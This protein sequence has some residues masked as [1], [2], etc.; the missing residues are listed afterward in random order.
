MNTSMPTPETRTTV[1]FHHND[2]T[3]NCHENIAYLPRA[4]VLIFNGANASIAVDRENV[5]RVSISG[6]DYQIEH[7]EQREGGNWTMKLTE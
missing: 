7:T 1:T 6:K 5:V 4:R 3:S 2:G